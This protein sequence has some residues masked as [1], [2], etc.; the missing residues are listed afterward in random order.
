MT[1]ILVYTSPARG[2]LYPIVPIMLELKRRGHEVSLRTLASQVEL[3]QGL[4]IDAMPISERIERLE[5]NDYKGRSQPS[6]GIRAL[7]TFAARAKREVPD[8]QAA[9]EEERPDALLVDCMTWGAASVAQASGMPWAQY[10]PYPLPMPSRDAP[11]FGPGFKPA[12]GPLGHLRDR[13]MRPFAAAMFDRTALESLNSI[14]AEAGVPALLNGSDVFALAPLVLYLTSEPFEYPRKDWPAAVHMVGPCAWDPPAE[15]PE[16]LARVE[17]PL[18]LVSTSSERQEDRRL[19]TTAL[20]AFANENVEI[21]ATLPAE[22]VEGIAVPANAHVEQFLPHAALLAKAACAITHG[23]AGVTQK[24]LAAGVPVCVVPFGRDQHEVARRVQVAGAGTRLLVGR[25]T[26]PRLRARVYEAMTMQ[27]G[28][29]R[30][31]DAFSAAGGPVAAADAFELLMRG[32]S[33]AGGELSA[34][35][36]SAAGRASMR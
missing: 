5:L 24:A 21:V 8:L 26:P 34:G 20:E 27:P 30:V 36:E 3:M 4:G 13:A 31:A 15:P 10:V 28:A 17:R 9:I 19:V 32:A 14:R 18:V 7:K 25:L 29:R 1:R 11:P 22:G 6:K 35:G 16:W 23:G 33:P 12:R 2:H